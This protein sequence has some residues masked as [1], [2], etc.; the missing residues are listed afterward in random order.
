M[1]HICSGSVTFYDSE[2]THDL[3]F[4]PFYLKM[5]NCLEEKLPV[6]LKETVIFFYSPYRLAYGVPLAVDDLVQTALAYRG[7][8]IRFYLQHKM[9]C[10]RMLFYEV[11]RKVSKVATRHARYRRG[12]FTSWMETWSSATKCEKPCGR[13]YVVRRNLV[14]SLSTCEERLEVYVCARNWVSRYVVRERKSGQVYVRAEKVSQV[15]TTCE[16]NLC[17]VDYVRARR[18][19]S[20][21]G[22]RRVRKVRQEVA[23]TSRTDGAGLRLCE[24]SLVGLRRV[25]NDEDLESDS[26]SLKLCS[27]HQGE[28]VRTKAEAPTAGRQ[29]GGGAGTR[30][31][32]STDSGT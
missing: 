30:V 6:V 5:R 12:R 14:K 32:S 31:D 26:Q 13:V 28:R 18:N 29:T 11:A 9:L 4:R 22:L 20:G 23:T 27:G 2:E 3:E 8:M 15:A 17:H 10:P 19:S 24:G 16:G 1:F 7:K 25:R 21:L